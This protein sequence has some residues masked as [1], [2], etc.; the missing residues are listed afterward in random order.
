MSFRFLFNIHWFSIIQR[1]Y[2]QFDLW[3]HEVDNSLHNWTLLREMVSNYGVRN[4][5][6]VA[7]CQLLQHL[8]Y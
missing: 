5:L 3:N 7:R 1:K 6:L 2:M 4:S 8:K